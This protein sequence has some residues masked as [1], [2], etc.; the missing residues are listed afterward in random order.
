MI[1]RIDVDCSDDGAVMR[2]YENASQAP[3]TY[4]CVRDTKCGWLVETVISVDGRRI[5][6]SPAEPL[7][8][9]AAKKM[10]R[11]LDNACG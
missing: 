5:E 10:R 1:R 7:P 4:E 3:T 9:W 11:A 6:R 8:N 2:V